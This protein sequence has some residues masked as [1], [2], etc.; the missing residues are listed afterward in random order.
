MPHLTVVRVMLRSLRPPRT[1][2]ATSVEPAWGPDELGSF[3]VER[4]QAVLI[5]REPEEI[6]LLGDDR[7]F[8]A[9]VGAGLAAV[10]VERHVLR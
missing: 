2:L 4:Q 7:G 9:A 1:K 10:G 6:G 8:L 5:G 3:A